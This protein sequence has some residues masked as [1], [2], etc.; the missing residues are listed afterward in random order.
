M[1]HINVGLFRIILTPSIYDSQIITLEFPN[2]WKGHKYCELARTDTLGLRIR[3][4]TR[5]EDPRSSHSSIISPDAKE[6]C[7]GLLYIDTVLFLD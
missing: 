7:N 3:R 1:H 5:A 6:T 2:V 4:L